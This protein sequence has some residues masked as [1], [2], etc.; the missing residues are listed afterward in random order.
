ME[1]LISFIGNLLIFPV[2]VMKN[3]FSVNELT[4]IL[5]VIGQCDVKYLMMLQV[6]TRTSVLKVSSWT[7]GLTLIIAIM[8][9]STDVI[10]HKFAILSLTRYF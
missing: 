2:I 10:L 8:Y 5:N 3:I 9:V 1:S 6:K 7:I 4:L